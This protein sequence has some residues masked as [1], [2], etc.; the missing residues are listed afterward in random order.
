MNIRDDVYVLKDRVVKHR[1]W[2][3]QYPELDFDV[4]KTREYIINELERLNFHKIETLSGGVKGVIYAKNSIST[5]AFRADMD[6]LA[7]E[8]KSGLVFSSK[9]SGRMHA[10]GH[11]GH[12]A[13]L[14]GLAEWVSLNRDVLRH[15]IVFIFQPAE[16]TT[17]GALPM[18]EAGVL[19]EPKVDAIFAF[20]IF[21]HIEQG[22]LGI[23]SGPLMAQTA[24]FDIYLKGKSS[25]G[26]M[27]HKGADGIVAASHLVCAL[28]SL[29][30]RR[31]DPL[32]TTLISIGHMEGGTERNVLAENVLLEG[33][34]RTFND[35][36]YNLLKE[37]IK[38][39][40]KGLE[41]SHGVKGKFEEITYYPVVY[42]DYELV[43]RLKKILSDEIVVDAKPVMI[44]E[45]FSY[46]QREIPGVLILLGA[47]NKNHGH[48]YPLHSNKFNFDEEILL[49]GIQTLLDIVLKF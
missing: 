14:L 30:T 24:E 28:Q 48:V 4:E 23:R 6:A 22:K 44:A 5:L 45:D 25:H 17:G 29:V 38:D 46:Y 36:T 13:I 35:E 41:L 2:F 40:L 1:R 42:N 26:A 39:L 49:I 27:P 32:E 37:D 10:C 31:V 20:H 11:D 34:I 19:K 33:I 8:E 7:I 15:N 16:E 21:P 3:H 47:R 18:I 43:N 9:I 12:M